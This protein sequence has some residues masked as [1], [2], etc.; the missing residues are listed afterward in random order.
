MQSRPIGLIFV[1]RHVMVVMTLK[2]F[3]LLSLCCETA[4]ML[5][6]C[7]RDEPEK[8]LLP[9]PFAPLLACWLLFASLPMQL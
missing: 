9:L 4:L 7:L 1:A 3:A 2:F 5:D 8:H 6:A